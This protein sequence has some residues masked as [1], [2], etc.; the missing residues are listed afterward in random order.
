MAWNRHG[1]CGIIKCVYRHPCCPKLEA[2]LKEAKKEIVELKATLKE[3]EKEM[4]HLKATL[5]NIKDTQNGQSRRRR[6][7]YSPKK[8]DRV[9]PGP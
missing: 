6:R 8:G 7:V 4:A 1:A 2:G 5:E 3:S 9:F